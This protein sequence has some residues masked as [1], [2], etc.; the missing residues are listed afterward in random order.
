M[1]R[2]SLTAI[3]I[4]KLQEYY[5]HPRRNPFLA[6]GGEKKK[7]ERKKWN[8]LDLVCFEERK[9]RIRICFLNHYNY[10]PPR[11]TNIQRILHS[12]TLS[13]PINIFFNCTWFQYSPL[14]IPFI[15][16]KISIVM[17]SDS[18]IVLRY[19]GIIITM[20]LTFPSTLTS[21]HA[22]RSCLVDFFLFFFFL[23]FVKWVNFRHRRLKES[24][25]G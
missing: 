2:S 25:E 14:K 7:K 12:I 19:T 9:I 22:R 5:D 21:S 10:E 24:Q 20:Y 18:E 11:H 1:K 17:T 23:Y 15:R 4:V 16:Y 8:E 6:K 13:L 3:S